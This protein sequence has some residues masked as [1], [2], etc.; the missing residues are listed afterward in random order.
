MRNRHRAP[1][2]IWLLLLALTL[3]SFVLFEG[4]YLASLSTLVIV[5]I[6]ACRARLVVV[7]FM[8]VS[9]AP[10]NWRPLYETW[11]FVA[12]AIIVIGHYV[13]LARL[14]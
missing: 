8:E 7:H 14:A 1:R 2:V 10:E 5:T 12:A 6:A 3:A 13:T 9:Q 4:R 11:V